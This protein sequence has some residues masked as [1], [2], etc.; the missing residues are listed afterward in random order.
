MADIVNVGIVTVDAI[1]KSIDQVP[2]PKELVLFD[3][4][5]ITTGGCAVNCAFDL[6]KMGIPNSL[7]MKVGKD[8]LGD[9]VMSQ[10][11]EIGVDVSGSI[12]E[13]ETNTPFYIRDG[14]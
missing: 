3:K 5:M 9:F 14:R 8:M 4:L 6:A 12:C 7:V 2:A 1:G 11:K 10:A 13:K